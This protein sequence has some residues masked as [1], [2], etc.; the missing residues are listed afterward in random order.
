M[1]DAGRAVDRRGAIAT[2]RNLYAASRGLTTRV[3]IRA[4]FIKYG[5]VQ[6]SKPLIRRARRLEILGNEKLS[7]LP[8]IVVDC[9]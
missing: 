3:V 2:L 9:K 8:P 1:L 7:K 4:Q 6:R 5:K